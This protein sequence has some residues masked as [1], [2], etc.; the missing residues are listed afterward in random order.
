[1]KNYLSTIWW[2][3]KRKVEPGFGL[4]KGSKVLDVGSGD[5]PFWRADVLVDKLDLGDDQRATFGGIKTN[6]KKIVDADAANL[7]FDDESFD[8]VYC[9]HLLEHV[10]DPIKVVEEILRVTKKDG[11]G[12]LEVPNLMNEAT[13][14]HPTHR[15]IIGEGK[16][17]ELVFYRKSKKLHELLFDNGRRNASK[18]GRMW[19]NGE[20]VFIKK[21]WRKAEGLKIVVVDEIN[22]GY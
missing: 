14:P 11:G 22:D 15:W 16:N 17:G 12:Y 9:S 4:A 20:N 19:T 13:M 2:W 8:F 21:Y 10:T 3:Y 5:K 7:P 1:M 18:T 6:G